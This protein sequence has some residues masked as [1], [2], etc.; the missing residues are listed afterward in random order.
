M[1]AAPVVPLLLHLGGMVGRDAVEPLFILVY[2]FLAMTLYPWSTAALTGGWKL[3]WLIRPADSA[4][5]ISINYAA[6]FAATASL[7]LMVFHA[8]LYLTMPSYLGPQTPLIMLFSLTIGMLHQSL[9]LLLLSSLPSTGYGWAFTLLYQA[10]LHPL[11]FS[12]LTHGWSQPYTFLAIFFPALV[13]VMPPPALEWL[14]LAIAL[15]LAASLLFTYLFADRMVR[16][17]ALLR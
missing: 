3:F 9:A 12:L 2:Q 8:L 11:A 4:D 14:Y 5:Y 7:P 6:F 10:L 17:Q 16:P 13:A 15:C 1:V